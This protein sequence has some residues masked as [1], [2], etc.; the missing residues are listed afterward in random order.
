M[1]AL[2][3]LI[4]LSTLPLQAQTFTTIY[5]FQ[6]STDGSLPGGLAESPNGGLFGFAA[7]GG[8]LNDCTIF[9]PYGC[10]NVFQITPAGKLTT[11]YSFGG[12][13]GQDP[14][15]L[16]ATSGTLYGTT[17]QGALGYGTAFAI[18]SPNSLAAEYAFGT[19][20]GIT[21]ALYPQVAM[22]PVKDGIFYGTGFFGG[23][24]NNGAVFELTFGAQGGALESTV[25]SFKGAPN[26][27]AGPNSPLVAAGNALYGTTE[28][29]GSGNCS[30][31]NEVGC[32]TFFKI[33]P[34]GET[35]LHT[36]TG[37]DGSSPGKLISAGN[38]N[39]YGVTASGGS[40]GYGTIFEVTP[41][42]SVTTLFTFS[43]ASEGVNPGG[44]V[45]DSSGNLFGTTLNGGSAGDGV[46]FELSPNGNG[47]WSEKVLYSFLGST[48]G[49]HPQPP[50]VVNSAT[51]TIYGVTLEG[52]NLSCFSPDGCGTVFKLT[53]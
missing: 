50:I 4:L 18:S 35:V 7:Y 34:T 21:D 40:S 3:W 51:R 20:G 38:G 27:G 28:Y 46:I 42:G 29:G 32:G 16:I 24:A 25:Y 17:S 31:G 9:P 12:G 45:R 26:D 11:L 13:D 10:G 5:T 41:A 14:T 49:T 43:L 23:T 33:T 30:N 6:G 19:T 52:G 48:D 1:T 36:F 44:L 37:P 53:Y 2:L 22:T 39:F 8:N 15:S 47:G